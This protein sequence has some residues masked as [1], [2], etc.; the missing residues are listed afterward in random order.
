MSAIK[1]IKVIYPAYTTDP[2]TLI[3]WFN[4][5]Y[6]GELATELH[7]T[8]VDFKPFKVDLEKPAL[9][10]FDSETGHLAVDVVLVPALPVV[11]PP[12]QA[13]EHPFTAIGTKYE[14]HLSQHKN[15]MLTVTIDHVTSMVPFACVCDIARRARFNLERPAK[16]VIEFTLVGHPKIDK[17]VLPSDTKEEA[18]DLVN[19][20]HTHI[21]NRT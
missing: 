6:V 9:K 11:N 7:C 4:Q 16:W 5:V 12:L 21:I 10:L 3:D 8:L 20:I 14:L 15:P 18:G 17:L 1:G 13:T 2:Q 19:L